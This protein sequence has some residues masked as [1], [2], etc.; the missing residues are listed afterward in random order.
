[1][2]LRAVRSYEP[3]GSNTH[4]CSIVG[5]VGTVQWRA[6]S[7]CGDRV[8]HHQSRDSVGRRGCNR[9]VELSR[10]SSECLAHAVLNTLGEHDPD[11]A[12]QL[13]GERNDGFVP[14]SEVNRVLGFREG[15]VLRGFGTDHSGLKEITASQFAEFEQLF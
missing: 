12:H 1:M 6:G 9:L 5:I 14:L 11:D 8:V 7:R 4:A 10:L 2:L 15:C 3:A 13:V